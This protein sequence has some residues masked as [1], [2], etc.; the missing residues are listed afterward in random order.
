MSYNQNADPDSGGRFNIFSWM[1]RDGRGVEP[2]ERPVM[3]NPNIRNFFKLFGRKFNQIVTLNLMMVVGN[4]P[5]FFAL[6]VMTGYFSYSSTSPAYT[7]FAQLNGAIMH[8]G[9]AFASAIAGSY[10]VQTPITVLSSTDHVFLALACLA[11]LTFG[12]VMVGA[13]YILRNIVREEPIFLLQDFFY[14]IRRNLRQS[15]IYGIMDVIIIAFIVYDIIFFNLNYHES[16]V[17]SMMFF[18]AIFLAVIY[19]IMRMY[20]YIMMLTFDLSILKLMKNSLI[21]TVLGIKRNIVAVLGCVLLVFLNSLLLGIY[22][23]LGVI[24][25]FVI[26]FSLGLFMTAYAAYP[27]I[28]K[29][30]IA[31]YYNKDGTPINAVTA[32]TDAVSSSEDE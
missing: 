21:F 23:P 6:A 29:Y 25:P 11:L 5:I 13:S 3:E 9:G 31:P 12:P 1:S 19:F 7:L 28:D 16:I 20:I 14:A 8:G 2:G 17:V 10:S 4:F 18:A 32:E 24:V 22:Y 27:V 26:T 15:I 30:M